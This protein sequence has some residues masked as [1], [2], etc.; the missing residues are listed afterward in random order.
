LEARHDGP[1]IGVILDGLGLGKDTAL[2]GGEVLVGDA[3]SVRRFAHLRYVRAPGGDRAAEQPWRM[4]LAY[5]I[6]AGESTASVRQFASETEQALVERMI[7]RGLA[8][9]WTSSMGRLFDAVAAIMGLAGRNAF[10]AQAAVLVEGCADPVDEKEA[11]AMALV[12][13]EDHI[14]LD[15]RPLVRSLCQDRARGVPIAI[16]AARFHRGL[17]QAVIEVAKQARAQL[18]VSCVALSGGVFMNGVLL[19]QCQLGL[20]REGFVVHRP[21][22]TPPNDGGLALGQL[23]IASVP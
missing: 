23:A 4:A 9:P 15:A 21:R 6:D 11:Y 10:E 18:G 17:T 1:A 2:W 14:E 19:S 5:L 20:R 12:R 16:M 13:C 3:R 22:R 7:D 8:S